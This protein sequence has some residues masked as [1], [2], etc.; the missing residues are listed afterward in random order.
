MEYILSGE[1]VSL[2]PR[3]IIEALK[4]KYNDM[5]YR[6]KCSDPFRAHNV[7]YAQQGIKVFS[8]WL[9]EGYGFERFARYCLRPE[10]GFR[11]GDTIDRIENDKDYEPGN[12]RFVDQTTQ[13]NN[14]STNKYLIFPDGSRMTYSD[15]SKVFG[16]SARKISKNVNKGFTDI[17]QILEINNRN[18]AVQCFYIMNPYTDRPILQSQIESDDNNSFRY[19]LDFN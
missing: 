10:V 12:I 3:I 2:V 5:I 6:T 4:D 11:I 17:N 8:E 13:N 16:I 15:C 19:A 14:N 1:F 18:Y 7:R 9:E